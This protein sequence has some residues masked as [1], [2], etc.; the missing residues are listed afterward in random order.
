MTAA[1]R[2]AFA[3]KWE[4]DVDPLGELDPIER[5]RRAEAARK[6]HYARMALRSAEV[7]RAR[8]RVEHAAPAQGPS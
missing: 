1:A 8:L 4:Q 6:A 2:A 5:A 3:S 7:R